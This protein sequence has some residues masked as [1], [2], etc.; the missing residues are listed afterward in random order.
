ML[1]KVV[2]FKLIYLSNIMEKGIVFVSCN[3]VYKCYSKGY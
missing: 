1:Y 2:N 3:K